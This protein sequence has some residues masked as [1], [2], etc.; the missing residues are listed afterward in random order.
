MKLNF[1]P[2]KHDIKL[3]VTP[4]DLQIIAAAGESKVPRFEMTAYTGKA[5]RQWWSDKPIV[6]DI[7]GI[8]VP[9]R[10]VPI[11]MNH[12]AAEGV[13]HTED[14]SKLSEGKETRLTA[15]GIISRDTPSARDV[16]GS[17]GRGFPWQASISASISRIEEIEE[18]SVEVNGRV[19]DAPVLVVRASTLREISFVDL[20]ADDDTT[21][22]VAASAHSGETPEGLN[23]SKAEKNN[24]PEV[25][26]TG[27]GEN[28]TPAPQ[29]IKA[30][31]S[32]GDDLENIR[33]KANLDATRQR[34]ILEAAQSVANARPELADEIIDAAHRAIEAGSDAS[35]FELE[36]MRTKRDFG[37]DFGGKRTDAN[38]SDSVLEAA[39][40]MSGGMTSAELEKS[41]GERELEAAHRTYGSRLGLSEVVMMAAQQHGYHAPSVRFDLA[42]CLRAAFADNGGLKLGSTLSLPNIL[43]NVANKFARRGFNNVEDTWRRITKIGTSRDFKQKSTN[44]LVGD[45]DMK[46]LPPSGK[47]EHAVPGEVN[48]TNQID[49]YARMLRIDRRHI[50]N[51][52]L[53]AL[54]EAPQKLG[55]GGALALNT[56]FWGVFNGG[57]ATYFPTDNSNGN[58]ISGASTA[59]SIT[60][61]KTLLTAILTQTDPDG[62][63]LGLKPSDLIL[64]T[65]VNLMT[66][67]KTIINSTEI[68]NPAA[69]AEFG[70]VNPYAGMFGEAY[71]TY[72]STA[73]EWFF[74]VKPE[75]M[76]LLATDFLNGKQ[77]PTIESAQADF[78][79]LGIDLRGYH[80]FG[81]SYQEYRAGAMSKGAA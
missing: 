78:D 43:S 72:L 1:D 74:V 54:T 15:R 56:D 4:A 11:R 44:T 50:V 16:A 52:D 42:G 49:T 40:C 19:F 57:L 24:G 10:A 53:D 27:E 36:C 70:T 5:V 28:N 35:A 66:T 64:L 18:G 32:I 22:R 7:E 17:A 55:R 23:M 3:D 58:Y 68:R 80:D 13:G 48:Y 33:T 69:T 63:S 76:P 71:T 29:T 67:A 41:F 14:V 62:K 30:S 12:S 25:K 61:V 21:A 2:S 20:G 51:D 60:S 79:E 6:I 77:E 73:T 37:G 39:L 75:V 26:A 81:T 8:G 46:K 45:Y 59:L 9:G 65:S 47:I 31:G 34:K 38:L